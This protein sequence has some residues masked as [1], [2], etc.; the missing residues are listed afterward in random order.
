MV[1]KIARV[2]L[3]IEPDMLMLETPERDK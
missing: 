3:Q 2:I 1:G